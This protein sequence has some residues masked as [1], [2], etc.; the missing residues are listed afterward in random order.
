[1]IELGRCIGIEEGVNRLAGQVLWRKVHRNG[2]VPVRP[3]EDLA[4]AL[5]QL[6]LKVTSKR[7][8]PQANHRVQC[9]VG[10]RQGNFTGRAVERGAQGG[11]EI[12][13]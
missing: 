6:I 8:G 4:D 3:I 1:M 12:E 13:G 5:L 7:H 10:A 2:A 9:A 11:D